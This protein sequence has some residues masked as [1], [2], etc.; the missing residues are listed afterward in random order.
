MEI[1]AN[2]VR[3]QVEV[4]NETKKRTIV[5]LHGFT[6]SMKTWY[7]VADRLKDF[8]L[9]FVDL[10]GHGLTESPEPVERYTMDAQIRDLEKIFDGLTATEF[11]L[12][13][14]SMGGRT[15]LAYACT[16][17]ERLN[18]LVLESASPGLQ[19]EN[20]QMERRERDGLLAGRI[21]KDGVPAFVDFWENISLFD[22]Q[23]QLQDPVKQAVRQERLAQNP[24]GLA[25]SLLG[26][27]TGSQNS[28]WDALKGL[29]LPVLLLAGALDLKFKGINEAMLALLPNARLE[30]IEAGHAIH[31]EKPLE[32]ATMVE[33]Y[34]TLEFRGGKS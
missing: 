28:F 23:K 6:G 29:H 27:G 21:L 25:N 18:A 10:I 33:E 30:I 15:A 13:G 12:V 2:G 32:F 1:S 26:M 5:F 34:L 14:Y 3:Y 11:T 24:T 31:V 7:P 4:R 8:K 19:T 20:E 17:P 9:I 16:Y 22:S